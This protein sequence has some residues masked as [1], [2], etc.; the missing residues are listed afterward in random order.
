MKRVTEE[1]RRMACVTARK[2]DEKKRESHK[3][4]MH[5]SPA[6]VVPQQFYTQLGLKSQ[7]S[8]VTSKA[9]GISLSV[10]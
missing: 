3:Q 8:S 1:E 10:G 2:E 7:D 6:H 5:K 4:A 9:G